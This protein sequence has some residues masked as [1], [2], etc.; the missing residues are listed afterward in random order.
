M[1][2][3]RRQ[4]QANGDRGE[5]EGGWVALKEFGEKKK[6]QIMGFLRPKGE[7]KDVEASPSQ[8]TR[9]KKKK[10]ELLS[11]KGGLKRRELGRSEGKP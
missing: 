2:P 5:G 9:R 4:N 1:R 6:I 7:M 10:Y 8:L 3:R 11:R